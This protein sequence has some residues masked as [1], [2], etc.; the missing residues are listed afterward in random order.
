[1]DFILTTPEQLKVIVCQAVAD[2]LSAERQEKNGQKEYE[3]MSVQRLVEYLDTCGYITTV[4]TVYSYVHQKKIPFIK[5][6]GKLIFER[7]QVD[8]WLKAKLKCQC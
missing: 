1:M 4:T 7:R 6:N 2:A 5:V 8:A 3:R